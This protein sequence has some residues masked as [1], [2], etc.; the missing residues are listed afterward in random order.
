M[1]QPFR[2]TAVAAIMVTVATVV[3]ALLLRSAGESDRKV[4]TAAVPER[5]DLAP[6]SPVAVAVA[7]P[8]A[9]TEPRAATVA[10]ALCS[11]CLDEQ[12]VLN[13]AQGFL[14]YVMPDHLGT[15]AVP[16]AV[17]FP[18]G[19]TYDGPQRRPFLPPGLVDAPPRFSIGQGIPRH[20]APEEEAETWIV[21]IQTGWLSYS[22][23]ENYI[24]RGDLPEVARS[25]PPLKRET[26]ILIHA[27]TGEVTGLSG[28]TPYVRTVDPS[29]NNLFVPGLE[30][31]RRRAAGWFEANRKSGGADVGSS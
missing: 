5:G 13:V 24:E 18:P 20:L 30:E 4:P 15:R 21:W 17:E 12:G 16:F 27:K 11:G 22:A 14:F 19:V 1:T 7:V 8:E 9:I 2:K 26:Y 31:A 3:A 6:P 29:G 25:W 28:I 10:S 23:L